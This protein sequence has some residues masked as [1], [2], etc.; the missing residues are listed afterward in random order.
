MPEIEFES[1]E[2]NKNDERGI[3]I[4]EFKITN[5]HFQYDNGRVTIVTNDGK[6]IYE[7]LSAGND[8][9]ISIVL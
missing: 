4:P 9:M 3:K 8:F 2:N 7:N 5:I 1:Y 6:V